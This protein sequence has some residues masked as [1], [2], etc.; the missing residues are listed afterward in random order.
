M[1]LVE[2][3]FV[4]ELFILMRKYGVAI[5]SEEAECNADDFQGYLYYFRSLQSGAAGT[6]INIP[7]N[8]NIS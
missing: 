5:E 3:A 7:I 2:K 1:N 6:N 4:A 8:E